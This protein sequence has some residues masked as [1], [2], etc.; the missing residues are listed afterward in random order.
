MKASLSVKGVDEMLEGLAKA[1]EDVDEAAS[2]AVVA[3]G[4][5]A[6]AGFKSRVPVDTGQL[7]DSLVVTDPEQEGN[8]I[9][10]T[11]GH[12]RTGPQKAPADVARYGNVQEFGSSSMAA[13]PYVRPTMASDKG[14]INR[15]MVET[16]KER[17]VL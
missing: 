3:G 10:V 5:V 14:K 15:A 6:L 11:M 4:A 17:G 12:P 8:V 16:L 7:R 9:T 1:G 2:E 13:Q